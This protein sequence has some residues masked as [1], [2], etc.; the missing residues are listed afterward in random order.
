MAIPPPD[1]FI[2]VVE[3]QA[4]PQGVVVRFD[5]PRCADPDVLAIEVLSAWPDG[6]GGRPAFRL[7]VLERRVR[8]GVPVCVGPVERQSREVPWPVEGAC[9]V[10]FNDRTY[11]GESGP[12]APFELVRDGERSS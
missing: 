10:R 12:G 11:Y 5:H 3:A 1:K 6:E 7:A 8:R 2:A 4:G 9:V